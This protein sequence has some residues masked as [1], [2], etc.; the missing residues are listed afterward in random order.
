MGAPDG[1]SAAEVTLLLKSCCN[2]LHIPAHTTGAFLQTKFS[3]GGQKQKSVRLAVTSEAETALF[4][5]RT[6]Q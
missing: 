5:T 2:G 6:F 3:P 1:C 4:I